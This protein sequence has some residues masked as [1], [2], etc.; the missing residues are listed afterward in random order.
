MKNTVR[1]HRKAATTPAPAQR[2]I[3]DTLP[4]VAL[5]AYFKRRGKVYNKC[6]IADIGI[7]T[8]EWERAC[9]EQIELKNAGRGSFFAEAIR[10]KL[11]G[12]RQKVSATMSE[13]ELATIQSNSLTQLLCDNLEFQ[14]RSAGEFSGPKADL[15]CAGISSLVRVTQNRLNQA[16]NATFDANKKPTKTI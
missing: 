11:A 3:T 4:T 5:S 13:L 9:R 1:I 6:L 8:E 14:S 12:G 7:S 15:F 2:K 16:F 10:E